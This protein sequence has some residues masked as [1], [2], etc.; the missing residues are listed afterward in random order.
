MAYAKLR[1]SF[2]LMKEV[3]PQNM[4]MELFEIILNQR[5]YASYFNFKND[6]PG[7]E[8]SVIGNWLSARYSNPRKIY[9]AIEHRPP[10]ND[11][12]DIVLITQTAMRHGFE[13]T[14][15]VDSKTVKR[16]H[17]NKTL[18]WKEFSETEFH[19]LINTQIFNKS[20]K[21][22]KGEP[23]ERK[24]LIIYSDEPEL[25]SNFS[26][27]TNFRYNQKTFFDETWF[28]I[29]P[30]INISGDKSQSENCQLFQLLTK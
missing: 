23:Y 6:K 20:K 28:M 12:P 14:E 29:P 21:I 19:S 2:Q 26:Y 22:F 9:R 4:R 18:D 11:P 7:T 16:F 13:V 15:F 3:N 25:R 10:P 1:A 30:K 27:L 24:F 8:I 5:Q 17:Q